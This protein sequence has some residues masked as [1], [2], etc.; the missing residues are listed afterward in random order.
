MS[1]HIYRIDTLNVCA[2]DFEGI[3]AAAAA[4]TGVV[5]K[6]VDRAESRYC[7]INQS[8]EVIIYQH[9]AHYRGSLAAVGVDGIGHGRS[10][11]PVDIAYH[12]RRAG[13][14]QYL[15]GTFADTVAAAGHHSHPTPK[16]VQ[17]IYIYHNYYT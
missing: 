14:R 9:I 6:Y 7:E 13:R 5:D 11:R 8:A 10:L 15:T 2:V 17:S 3:L 12:D 16:V 4:E 1:H